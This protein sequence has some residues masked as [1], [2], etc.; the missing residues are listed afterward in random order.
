[1]SATVVAIAH[2]PAYFNH[3]LDGTQQASVGTC[4][5][6]LRPERISINQEEGD[7]RARRTITHV[8]LMQAGHH[9]LQQK[10]WFQNSE[11]WLTPQTSARRPA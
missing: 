5:Q 10:V 7:C 9:L 11:F 1:M 4:R 3:L 2:T 8:L 6:K